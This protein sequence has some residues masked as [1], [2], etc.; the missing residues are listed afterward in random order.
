MTIFELVEFEPDVHL[1]I[2]LRHASLLFGEVAVTYLLLPTA[3]DSCRLLA[4]VL[5]RHSRRLPGWRLCAQVAM[6]SLEL[7]MMR[8]QLLTFKGLAEGT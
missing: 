3:A 6:P 2:R 5:I 8:K 4:K 7:V 1:T